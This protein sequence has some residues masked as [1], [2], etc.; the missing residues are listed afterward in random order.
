[1][2]ITI[3]E[4]RRSRGRTLDSKNLDFMVWGSDDPSAV[5]AAMLAELD[6][7]AALPDFE[8]LVVTSYSQQPREEKESVYDVS[9]GLGLS[10]EE[11]DRE[12]SFQISAVTQ[13]IVRPLA[14][15]SSYPAGAP[16][17][18]GIGFDSEKGYEGT[19]IQIPVLTWT[20]T[21]SI[22]RTEM[23]NAFLFQL[24]NV[25]ANPVNSFPFRGFAAGEVLYSGT[26]GSQRGNRMVLSNAFAASPNLTGL[27]IGA[28]TGIAKAGWDYLWVLYEK[29]EDITNKFIT[30]RPKAAYVDQV[31]GRSNFDLLFNPPLI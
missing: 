30:E 16:D 7:Y 24:M 3:K 5:E 19:D 8:N 14:R 28:M 29:D 11:D 13:H 18:P 15:I 6:D 10:S 4:V 20:E 12:L 17:L 9:V 22:A 27:S 31:Y 2:T 25:A 26:S 23:D 1:M 21:F